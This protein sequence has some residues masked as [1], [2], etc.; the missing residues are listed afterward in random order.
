[1]KNE[2]SEVF[3]CEHKE[4]CQW[5]SFALHRGYGIGKLENT[6][7][8]WREAHLVRC[9]GKLIKGIIVPN[10]VESDIELEVKK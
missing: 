5:Q 9:G 10:E 2:Y 6:A 7:L 8:A 3:Y 1:M 4:K